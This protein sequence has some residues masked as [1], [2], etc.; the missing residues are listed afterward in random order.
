[1]NTI[2]TNVKTVRPF[3][4]CALHLDID[5][6]L[7]RPLADWYTLPD[8]EGGHVFVPCAGGGGVTLTAADAKR[9]RPD[10]RATIHRPKGSLI[11]TG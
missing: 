11:L 10:F 1:M 8:H 3:P 5:G 4:G 9:L 7:R 6:R 2:A